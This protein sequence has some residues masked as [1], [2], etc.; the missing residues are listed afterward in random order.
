MCRF[1]GCQIKH[2]TAYHPQAQGLVERL[3]RSLKASLRAY[4]EPSQWYHNLPWVLLALRNSPK[5][6]SHSLSPTNFVFGGPVG[7]PREFYAPVFGGPVR[8]P[9]EF[10]A[11]E[12]DAPTPTHDYISN[13]SKYIANLTYHQP[14]ATHRHSYL[15]PTLF[16]SQCIFA[17]IHTS[18]PWPPITKGHFPS[19]PKT[20]NTLSLTTRPTTMWYR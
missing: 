6:D 16:S 14:R 18:H 3:N 15:D 9:R 1:L 13:F 11:P 17:Q 5:Q 19:Y 12:T 20:T 8:L 4:E 10:Y 7:L 2:S